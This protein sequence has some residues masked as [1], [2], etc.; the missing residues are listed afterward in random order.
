MKFLWGGQQEKARRL[1]PASLMRGE[2]LLLRRRVI[3]T[4]VLPDASSVVPSRRGKV[5]RLKGKVNIM[6]DGLYVDFFVGVSTRVDT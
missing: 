2:T 6:T 5:E 4:F 3:R 1:H